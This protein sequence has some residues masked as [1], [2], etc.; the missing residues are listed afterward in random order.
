MTKETKAFNFI[1]LEGFNCIQSFFV[2]LNETTF[3][4]VKLN[5]QGQN[6]LVQKYTSVSNTN[7]GVYNSYSFS[8]N[9]G[10]S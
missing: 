7:G 4:L 10:G 5:N 8:N 6:N 3:K 2:L 9:K 1:T